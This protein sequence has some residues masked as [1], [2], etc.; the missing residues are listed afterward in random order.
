MSESPPTLAHCGD[1]VQRMARLAD[2]APGVGQRSRRLVSGRQ[3]LQCPLASL[4]LAVMSLGP[5]AEAQLPPGDVPPA[6]FPVPT[7]VQVP[8]APVPASFWPWH[9]AKLLP[10]IAVPEIGADPNGGTTF[11]LLPVWLRTD[12]KHQIDRI[13]APDLYHNSYFGWGVHARL[14]AYPSEDEQLSIIAG[15]AQRVEHQFFFD[16]Q[17]GRARH[18]QWSVLASLMSERNGSLRYY[19]TGN[20]TSK[21][22]ETNYTAQQQAAQVKIGLNLSRIWQLAYTVRARFVDV[23]SGTLPGIRSIDQRFGNA[24]LGTDKY[25]LHRFSIGYDTRDDLTIPSSGMEWVVYAGAATS[26]AFNDAL[27]REAGFDGRGFW[28]SFH[29]TVVAAHVAVRYLLG[30]HNAPF[31]AL[32]TLGGDRSEVGGEQPLRGYGA[33]R[34]TDQ[35]AY[36]VTLE[37]RRRAFSF[38]AASTHVDIEVS[39]FVDAGRVFSGTGTFPLSHIHAIGGVGFRGTAKPFVVGYVDI[40]YGSE[41]AA[42]FTGINYPF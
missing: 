6:Q 27:Y 13:I 41:G 15:I 37:L 31:W 38:A 3:R 33:G 19:G 10:Y 28:S 36:S 12:A 9:D 20:D 35:N 32:S 24:I 26:G 23:Q 22:A 29:D 4:L 7:D 1:A 25:F 40:G 39:P 8:P 34:Y 2:T 16:Y 17:R 42:V 14:Y 21:S 18:E 5:A 11:G 30:D